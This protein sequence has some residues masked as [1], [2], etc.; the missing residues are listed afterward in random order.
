M[1]RNSCEQKEKEDSNLSGLTLG[2]VIM[3]VVGIAILVISIASA[4]MIFE[5]VPAESI[6]V[7]QG[8]IS[9]NLDWYTDPGLKWQGFGKVTYY[10]K[11]FQYWFSSHNDQGSKNDQSIRIRFNDGGHGKISGSVRV[12]LPNGKEKLTALHT[13]YGSQ[14]AIEHELVRPVFERS[15]YM[16]GPLMSSAESYAERRNQLIYYIED[17]AGQGIYKTTTRLQKTKDP[18]TGSEKTVALVELIKSDKAPGGLERSETSPLEDFG[19]KSY[20]L[21]INDMTYDS[22]VEEQIKS[23]Q[24]AIMEVQTAIAESRKAE[25]RAITAEQEGRAN[26]AKSKWE[27]EV[28][29]AR[30]VTEGEQK[31]EVAKLNR[32]AAEFYKQEQILRGEGDAR[33]KEMVMAAD[34]ALTPKLE[35]YEKV[36]TRFAQEFGKQKWVPEVVMG[37]NANANGGNQLMSMMDLLSMQAL[38]SLGLNLTIQEGKKGK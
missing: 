8:P 15:I 12:D 35:T 14:Q 33:Y 22:E 26:A 21:S 10:K 4:G 1:L 6:V 13:R 31:K 3:L 9:G 23:Q 11:S 34:G 38:K 32:D 16:S 17:Q 5:N 24:R 7:I 2:R 37:G 20:N 27:Q 28:I 29:K 36:M 19:L 18:I 30:V 25:Q